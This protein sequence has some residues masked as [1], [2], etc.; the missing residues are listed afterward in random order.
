MPAEEVPNFAHVERIPGVWTRTVAL[1]MAWLRRTFLLADAFVRNIDVLLAGLES[2]LRMVFATLEQEGKDLAN[3]LCV[4]ASLC[5][6]CFITISADSDTFCD[7][8]NRQHQCHHYSCK[9]KSNSHF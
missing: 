3:E 7:L 5:Q 8:W 6:C 4:C 2:F 1:R 9:V